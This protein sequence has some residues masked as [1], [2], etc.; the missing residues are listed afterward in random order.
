G[1]TFCGDLLFAPQISHTFTIP[2]TNVVRAPK[3]CVHVPPHKFVWPN[4]QHQ[5]KRILFPLPQKPR[6][7]TQPKPPKSYP[8]RLR[9]FPSLTSCHQLPTSPPFGSNP[10]PRPRYRQ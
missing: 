10:P 8:Y 2:A 3:R 4:V 7:T 9:L 6:N 1:E 5:G